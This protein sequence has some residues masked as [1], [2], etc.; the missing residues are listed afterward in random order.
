M[1]RRCD[2]TGDITMTWPY[3]T[4]KWE[5]IIPQ[6]IRWEHIFGVGWNGRI[7]GRM[8]EEIYKNN[9]HWVDLYF[10]RPNV[11]SVPIL[12][13]YPSLLWNIYK[14]FLYID[15]TPGI[16]SPCC[17]LPFTQSLIDLT[18]FRHCYPIS[19]FPQYTS[20]AILYLLSY[21]TGI[22]PDSQWGLGALR[23]FGDGFFLFQPC[24]G[25]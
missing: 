2:C 9:Q 5:S 24:P 22:C 1:C 12:C 4:W 20:P 23:R 3:L 7:W 8:P 11:C 25:L 21:S 19:S 15:R 13:T 10:R 18:W 16:C 6:D 17:G 14:I